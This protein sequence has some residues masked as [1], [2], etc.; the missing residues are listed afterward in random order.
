MSRELSAA[1]KAKLD[2]AIAYVDSV[3]RETGLVPLVSEVARAVQ[4]RPAETLYKTS[5]FRRHYRARLHEYP[6]KPRRAY[7]R[8][9]ENKA[10]A[11][12][13]E[14][15]ERTGRVPPKTEIAHAAGVERKSLN[16]YPRLGA[17]YDAALAG[18]KARG[19]P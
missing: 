16:R 7:S 19:L 1:Q 14:M 9:H 18:A 12:L 11:F 13:N 3:V 2:E 8:A 6:R 17:L 10:I 5:R 4:F 15:V